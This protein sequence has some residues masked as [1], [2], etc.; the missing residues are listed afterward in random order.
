MASLSEALVLLLIA[1]LLGKADLGSL[2][3]LFL[4]YETLA[5]LASAGFPGALMYF[6][7]TEDDTTRRAI[8][9]R[10]IHVGMGMGAIAAF[11]MMSIGLLDFTQPALL[12][13]LFGG[14]DTST[15]GES[16]ERVAFQYLLALGISAIFDVPA[17]LLPNLLVVE[18]RAKS[19]AA[20]GIIR[21]LGRT[22]FPVIP[23]ALGMDLWWVAGSLSVFGIIFG[24]SVFWFRHDLYRGAPI[25][26]WT[27]SNRELFKFAVPLGLTEAIGILN[28]RLDRF[29]VVGLFAAAV[30]AEYEVGAWQIPFVA[31][32][33]FSVGAAYTPR[34][35]A[36]F[37]EGRFREGIE[38]WKLSS[39]KVGLIVMPICMVFIVAAEES[40]TLLFGPQYAASAIVFRLYSIWTLLRI[41]AFGNVITAAGKPQFVLHAAGLSFLA[42]IALSVPLTLWLG[43]Y[44]AA[45]GTLVSFIPMILFYCAKIS[46]ATDVP[47][48]LIYPTLE[49]SRILAVLALPATG[50]WFLKENI[51]FHA[52]AELAICAGVVLTGFA[53]IGTLTKTIQ[54]DDWRYVKNWLTLRILRS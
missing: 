40:I 45:L 36:L 9:T 48:R 43:Y 21:S 15:D 11:I 16:G 28:K 12:D 54:A 49:V 6:L 5:L 3:A 18:G 38:I 53:L 34:F 31:T 39:V 26:R 52:G 46:E 1:R 19:A 14:F 4:T 10:F 35:R 44:G 51:T 32:I 24:L 47:F 33:P 37:A 29:L 2:A 22:L 7:P 23:I 17:R 42:N 8:V 13:G 20:V 25:I 27:T 30:V 50:A 41:A